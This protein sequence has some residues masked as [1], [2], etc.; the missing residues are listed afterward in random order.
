MEGCTAAAA[1]LG[2]TFVR[3]MV[4]SLDVSSMV[5]YD[6]EALFCE[7]YLVIIAIADLA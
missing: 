4:R 5:P 6:S 3:P 2:A 1:A 7:R